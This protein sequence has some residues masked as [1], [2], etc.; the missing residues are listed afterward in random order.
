MDNMPASY[1]FALCYPPSGESLAWKKTTILLPQYPV[2][3]YWPVRSSQVII[4]KGWA[5]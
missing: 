4:S 1:F 3:T 5:E 2:S